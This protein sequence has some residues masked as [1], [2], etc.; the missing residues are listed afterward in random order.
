MVQF[1]LM[2][3]SNK[4]CWTA[5]S[6]AAGLDPVGYR[7]GFN[8]EDHQSSKEV[9]EKS[10]LAHPRV[11]LLRSSG[12]IGA[13]S[14]VVNALMWTEAKRKT[15]HSHLK[16]LKKLVYVGYMVWYILFSPRPLTWFQC[17][18]NKVGNWL[19]PMFCLHVSVSPAAERLR[20]ILGEDDSTPTP[21]LFTEMDTLQREG[22]ELE[23]KESAR[24]T[25]KHKGIRAFIT[26]GFV[27]T[28]D[29]I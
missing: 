9:R 24:Y 12:S 16:D 26:S 22:D 20:H 14:H 10:F 28:F 5:Y 8:Q 29:R 23:W 4:P 21:T 19:C 11:T 15:H 18:L 13:I 3:N 6:T 27:V 7:H 2:D 17:D 1:G 25:H